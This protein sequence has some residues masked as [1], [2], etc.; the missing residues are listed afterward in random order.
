MNRAG[1]IAY[2][3]YCEARG[4][5]SF[6]GDPLPPFEQMKPDLQDAWHAAAE[7]VIRE[8]LADIS[9]TGRARNDKPSQT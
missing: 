2:D 6:N 3:A 7:A 9:D 4:W 1:R 5:Q 8:T